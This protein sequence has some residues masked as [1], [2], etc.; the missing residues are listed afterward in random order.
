MDAVS[1][2]IPDAPRPDEILIALALSVGGRPG[3]RVRK[4]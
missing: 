4:P 1:I 3:A 2:A